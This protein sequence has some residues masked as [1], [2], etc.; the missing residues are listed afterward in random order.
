MD[1]SLMLEL[2]Q[3]KCR[4]EFKLPK[5]NSEATIQ[6]SRKQLNFVQNGFHIQIQASYKSFKFDIVLHN[7]QFNQNVLQCMEDRETPFLKVI[8]C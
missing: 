7:L 2:A 4:F 8:I 3:H 1:F 5:G 6:K